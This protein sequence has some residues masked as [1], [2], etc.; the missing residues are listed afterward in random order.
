[1]RELVIDVTRLLSRGLE[2]RLPTGIDRVCLEYVRHFQGRAKALVRFGG[3]WVVLSSDCSRLV[4]AAMLDPDAGFRRQVLRCVGKGYLLNWTEHRQSVLLNLGHSGL[5]QPEYAKQVRQRKMLP[6]F[7]MHDLIPISHP[8]YSRIGEDEKHLRRLETM[9]FAGR[10]LVV[11]SSDTLE[12]LTDF[13]S[14]RG[15]SLPPTVVA[16]LAPAPLPKFDPPVKLDVPYFVMIGTI[17]PRKNHL[18]VLQV[19]RAL[20]EE[21]GTDAPHLVIVGQRG[22]ECE[23]VVDLLDRCTALQSHVHEVSGCSDAEL[24]G[25]LSHSRALLFPSFV[26]GFGMPLVEALALGVPVVASDLNVFREIGGNIPDYLNPVDGLGWRHA[27]LDYAEPD[28]FSR[29]AQCLRMRDFCTPTWS[30]HFDAVDAFLE[31]AIYT[32][33]SR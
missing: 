11:N 31:R 13:A 5:E 26:E 30:Q 24:V 20:V 7:F 15:W 21:L 23:Q 17:E 32:Q 27:I 2:G 8:E 29:Q 9:I 14:Q 6:V 22:W 12:A 18:L 25:W 1:M 10:G 19:W 28:S 4:F 16:H 3:R 33:M